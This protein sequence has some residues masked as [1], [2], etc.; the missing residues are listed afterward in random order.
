M[1]PAVAV[2]DL[3]NIGGRRL[4]SNSNE[5]LDLS[6]PHGAALAIL[7]LRGSVWLS[8]VGRIG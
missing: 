4:V 5:L 8:A 3:V 6:A 2:K 7:R 1:F